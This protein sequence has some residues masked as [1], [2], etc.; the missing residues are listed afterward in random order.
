MVIRRGRELEVEYK[1][2]ISKIDYFE[3]ALR[4]GGRGGVTWFLY[5][6]PP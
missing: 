6:F 1:D 3:I 2:T 5:R 4:R